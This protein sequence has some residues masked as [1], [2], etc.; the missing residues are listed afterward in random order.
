[1]A[2]A[3]YYF[4]RCVTAAIKTGNDEL[5]AKALYLGARCEQNNY[6]LETKAEG[7]Y[8]IAP[9]FEEKYRQNFRK[10]KNE[11]SKTKMFTDIKENCAYFR[12]MF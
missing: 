5:A 3:K 4:D 12:T 9:T 6:Y 11:F 7:W 8:F 1:M 2:K 10:I